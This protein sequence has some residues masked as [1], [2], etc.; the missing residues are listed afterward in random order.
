LHERGQKLE[1]CM[2]SDVCSALQDDNENVRQ[3][4]MRII[5]VLSHTYPE[6]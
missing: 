1:L 5:W 2:Y 3:S 6:R 4:A